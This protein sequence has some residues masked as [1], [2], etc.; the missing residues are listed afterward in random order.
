MGQEISCFPHSERTYL[1]EVSLV[2]EVSTGT[3]GQTGSSARWAAP[4]VGVLTGSVSRANKSP[5]GG[6][7]HN[8][9]PSCNS[10]EILQRPASQS[11]TDKKISEV[12]DGVY[13]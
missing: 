2:A 3:S 12:P 11:W 9:L 8:V 6:G 10:P 13:R 4:A 7:V 1:Y 5:C